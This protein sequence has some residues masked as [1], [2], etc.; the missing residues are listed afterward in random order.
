MSRTRASS[1]LIVYSYRRVDNKGECP[2]KG[3][4]GGAVTFS[5]SA[6][7]F[8]KVFASGKLEEVV[9]QK[10][11]EISSRFPSL[12]SLKKSLIKSLNLFP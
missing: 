3:R 12:K 6:L 8:L 7:V 9:D 5:N 11:E 4:G 2:K 10:L 1:N